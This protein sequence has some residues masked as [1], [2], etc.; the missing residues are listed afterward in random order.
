MTGSIAS[1]LHEGS[2]SEILADY[3]FSAWGTVTPIRR[4]DDY[5]I[6]LYGGLAERQGQRSI[7]TDYYV[8]QVKSTT[9][10]WVFVGEESVRWLIDYPIP[11]FLSCVDKNKGTLAVYHVTS[12]FYVSA[13]GKLPPRLE[14]VPEDCEGGAF[15]AWQGGEK[16]SLSAPILRVTL[17]D[18]IDQNKLTELRNVFTRWV[19]LDRQNLDLRRYG[20]LRFRMPP[21]YKVNEVPSSGIGELGNA[22]PDD[23]CLRRG[24]LTLAEGLECIGGQLG[25]RGDRRAALLAA[26]LLDH[27]QKEQPSHFE[28]EPRWQHRVPGELGEIVCGGLNALLP[29]PVPYRYAGIDVVMKALVGDPLVGRFL[30]AGEGAQPGVPADGASPAPLNT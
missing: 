6:D 5:G 8:V 22:V 26:L 11:I 25:R 30:M 13:M 9:D 4:Q 18:L 10:P 2:R 3:L 29:S 15:I 20:L 14:L 27:I 19:R 12:R 1:N 7:I 16:F 17:G 21:S 28:G 23:D 24:I